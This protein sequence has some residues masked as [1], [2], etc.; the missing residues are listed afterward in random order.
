MHMKKQRKLERGRG[1]AVVVLALLLATAGCD[2][3]L[4]VETPG[5]I[6]AETLDNPQ[7][8]QLLANSAVSRFECAFGAY[9]MTAGAL[10]N[11]LIISG[12]GS[13]QYPM[14]QRTLTDKAPYSTSDSCGLNGLYVPVS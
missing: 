3:F 6:L 10:G 1:K 4:T 2:K 8:A 5:E 11:E 14:D 9:I 7:Y 13:S 12:T